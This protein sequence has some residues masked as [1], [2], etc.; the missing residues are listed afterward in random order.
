M[1]RPFLCPGTSTLTQSIHHLHLSLRVRTY[2]VPA[3]SFA[4]PCA[5]VKI[6]SENNRI[7]MH[8]VMRALCLVH[9]APTI[10]TVSRP[11]RYPLAH[12][13]RQIE[14][15]KRAVLCSPHPCTNT[16]PADIMTRMRGFLDLTNTNLTMLHQLKPSAF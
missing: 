5:Q 13:K 1:P 15:L 9:M 8:T 14:M 7:A 16:E 4:D 3:N 12:R 11:S 6:D 10:Q 2:G